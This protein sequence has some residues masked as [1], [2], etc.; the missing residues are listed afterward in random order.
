MSNILSIAFCTDDDLH[1]HKK[2]SLYLRVNK[3]IHVMSDICN[4]LRW[5][6]VE[7]IHL[8]VRIQI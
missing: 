7:L 3:L 2:S 6:V 4:K 8:L 5:T 1:I